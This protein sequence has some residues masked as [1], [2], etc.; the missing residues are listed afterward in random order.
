MI[1]IFSYFFQS[2][3]ISWS[4]S[5]AYIISVDAQSQ[6]VE[7][8]FH[9]QKEVLINAP[10]GEDETWDLYERGPRLFV[11]QVNIIAKLKLND[12]T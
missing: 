1:D 4:C 11:Y 9:G 3:A 2:N 6:I 10:Q 8:F 5:T 12:N 7:Y